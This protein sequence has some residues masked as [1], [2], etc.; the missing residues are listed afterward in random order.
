[1]AKIPDNTFQNWVD[2]QTIDGSTYTQEREMLR[3]AVNDNFDQI[4]TLSTEAAYLRLADNFAVPA[5]GPSK[6]PI[7]ISVFRA[8]ASAEW[9][10]VASTDVFVQ[11]SVSADGEATQIITAVGAVSSMRFRQTDAGVWQ[12]MEKNAFESKAQLTKITGDGGGAKITATSSEDVLAKIVAQGIGLHSF[13]A[14]Y[15]SLNTPDGKSIRG[16]AH[17]TNVDFGWVMAQ[18]SAGGQW[19]NYLN[20]GTWLGWKQVSASGA[21]Q[22]ILWEGI[23]YPSDTQTVTP[24]KKLS[25]CQTGWVLVWSDYDKGV[26]SNNFQFAYTAIPKYHASKFNGGSVYVPIVIG[27]TTSVVTTTMKYLYISDNNITGH[28]DNNNDTI[29]TS[30]VCL[31]A[32]IEF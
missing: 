1:M 22:S 26:G 25:E 3:V 9:G 29:F 23:A 16:L 18:T 24:S 11:T 7:G 8:I 20:G 13:Y 2:G 32:V 6:F 27:H 4:E 15:D 17:M 31:R 19:M 21:T 10:A 30:D 5:D 14:P 12:P 28:A